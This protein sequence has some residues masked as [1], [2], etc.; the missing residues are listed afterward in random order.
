[1]TTITKLQVQR[2]SAPLA[3]LLSVVLSFV[4]DRLGLTDGFGGVLRAVVVGVV[5]VLMF[6]GINLAVYKKD[7]G[8]GLQ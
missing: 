7:S 2:W 4:L 1:M 8:R 5:T 6:F 3:V